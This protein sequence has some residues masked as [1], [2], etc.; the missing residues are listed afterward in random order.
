MSISGFLAEFEEIA[1]SGDYCFCDLGTGI[2][3]T[4]TGCLCPLGLGVGFNDEQRLFVDNYYL[5]VTD[6]IVNAVNSKTLE[7]F[8]ALPFELSGQKYLPSDLLIDS[9]IYG[10]SYYPAREH[11][12][13]GVIKKLYPHDFN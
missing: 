9:F 5:Q 1:S 6:E 4:V 10:S 3:Q 7:I 12:V 2:Q 8:T 11:L 13:S